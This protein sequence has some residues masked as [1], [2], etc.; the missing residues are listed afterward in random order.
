M[1][2]W[3]NDRIMEFMTFLLI[4][5]QPL[6]GNGTK[7]SYW[8]NMTMTSVFLQNIE[9]FKLEKALFLIK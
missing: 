3:K 8:K 7:M 6:K 5:L 1:H 2:L 4:W 9:S